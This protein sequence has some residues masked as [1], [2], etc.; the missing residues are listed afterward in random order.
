MRRA[1]TAVALCVASTFVNVVPAHATF[2][3]I[4]VDQVFPGTELAPH[5][6]YVMLQTQAP[7]QTA[8]YGQPFPLFDAAGNPLG[9]FATFCTTPRQ[10]CILPVVSP[11]CSAGD[12]PLPF[13]SNGRHILAATVWAE[14]L[15][16][17]TA[18]LV[19][20]GVVPHPSGRVCWGDCALRT[21][22]GSGPVDCVAYGSY[23]G[24]NAPFGNPAMSPMLGEA[25]VAVPARQNQF[26]LLPPNNPLLDSS[27]G[28]G[29]GAPTPENFHGDHG[30]IDGVAGDPEG[31]GTSNVRDIPAEVAVLFETNRRCRLPATRRGADANFDT[32]VSAADVIATIRIVTAAS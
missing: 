5:A 24:D 22:C 17:V 14:E 16:C 10:S 23:T 19:A 8:V 12:C 26:L 25:L 30:A 31:T 32:R 27:K 3:I 18:D 13:D 9:T 6:Q 1:S 15:F 2:H 7:V 28:F 11:A 29:V 21:D 20:T 4:V